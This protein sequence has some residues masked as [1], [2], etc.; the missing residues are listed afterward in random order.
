[1]FRGVRFY[2]IQLLGRC[3][4]NWTFGLHKQRKI[5]LLEQI[6]LWGHRSDD[7]QQQM[8]LGGMKAMRTKSDFY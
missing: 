2:K 5:G 1:M 7:D 6:D 4:K 8:F 3:R